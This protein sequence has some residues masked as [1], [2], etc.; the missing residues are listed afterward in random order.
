MEKHHIP[1]VSLFFGVMFLGLFI[2]SVF[3]F[4]WFNVQ[5]TITILT[6]QERI[7]TLFYCH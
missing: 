4:D 3:Y 6:C 7:N 2:F 1:Y 5:K